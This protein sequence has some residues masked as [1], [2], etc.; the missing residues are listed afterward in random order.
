MPRA[1]H[2]RYQ[3]YKLYRSPF[4]SF[5]GATL[6][7]EQTENSTDLATPTG[8]LGGK[9]KATKYHPHDRLA[10]VFGTTFFPTLTRNNSGIVSDKTS[11]L[12]LCSPAP[13]SE[14]HTRTLHVSGA[15]WHR[16]WTMS[17]ASSWVGTRA[18]TNR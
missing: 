14:S 10:V 17:T 6:R 11:A 13:T 9:P 15:G 5:W 1:N 4:F 16:P 12:K 3:Y 7:R 8:D 2:A 18:E